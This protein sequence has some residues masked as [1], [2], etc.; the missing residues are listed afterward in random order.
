MVQRAARTIRERSPLISGA[1][2]AYAPPARSVRDMDEVSRRKFLLGLAASSGL[3]L[4]GC[5]PWPGGCP[6][7]SRGH[8]RSARRPARPAPARGRRPAARRSSTSSSTCRRTTPTTRTSACSA[9]ATAITCTHGVPANSNPDPDGNDGRACST[10]RTPAS[11]VAACR[12]AGRRRTARSTAAAWT[13][14][15]FDDNT[16]AMRYWDGTDLPFYW[17]LASTFPLCDRWFASAPAQTYPNRLYLQA[18]DVARTSSRPT[19]PRRSRCPTRRAARSGT[20]STRTASR[21]ATTRGTSPTSLLFPKVWNANH[22]KMR[23]FDQFLADCRTGTLPAVSIVSPGVAAYT[24]E[25]PADIQLGEA[26]S[27]SI[28]NAVMHEPGVAEDGAALHVRRARRLLRPRARRRPRSRP[29]TSRPASTRR[30]ARPPRGTSTASACPAF[31]ISP[32]A[33]AQLRVAR[34]ARPHVGAALHR[35]E[36]QPRRAAPAATRTPTTC[37]TA[38]TSGGRRVPRAADARRARACRRPG[39][40]CTP[41]IPPP[42]TQPTAVTPVAAAPIAGLGTASGARDRSGRIPR[43][44]TRTTSASR[45]SVSSRAPAP[46]SGSVERAAAGAIG[47]APECF[48]VFGDDARGARGVPG[49]GARRRARYHRSRR[50]DARGAD[51]VRVR[52]RRRRVGRDRAGLPQG[53]RRSPRHHGSVCPRRQRRLRTST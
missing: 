37:S 45:C 38:S 41:E 49:R 9:G 12:R 27:A 35:D 26:Y 22:D 11:P 2:G 51:L 10:R 1:A 52:T 6:V 28:I 13:A 39:S 43:R 4:A 14:S 29:T 47:S 16:N 44:P 30:P 17:S 21:G 24:E 33:R 5:R 8:G 3:A 53:S 34:G 23:T 32:F 50:H 18:G 31:V 7:P 40:T 15:S 25:N 42:P 36:V 19:S 20:S 46:D 48:H